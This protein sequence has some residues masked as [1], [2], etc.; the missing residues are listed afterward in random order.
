MFDFSNQVVIVTG[1]TG[2]LGSAVVRAF[3]SAGAKLVIPDRAPDRAQ[4]RLPDL[5]DSPGHYLVGSMDA[6]QAEAMETLVR[7][8]VR[9]R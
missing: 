4:Q 2:N 5:A 8:I 3:Q 1:G 6:T 7:D 9:L